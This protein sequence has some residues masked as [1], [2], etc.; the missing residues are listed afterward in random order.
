MLFGLSSEDCTLHQ[1]QAQ[2]LHFKLS[3]GVNLESVE[4]IA[5]TKST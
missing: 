2:N 5:T 4:F 1:L 3:V